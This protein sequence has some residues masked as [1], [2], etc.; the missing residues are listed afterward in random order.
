MAGDA[1]GARAAVERAHALFAAHNLD[2]VT[3]A[4]LGRAMIRNGRVAQA[5][6]VVDSARAR[7]RP[8]NQFEDA[9]SLGASADLALARG[10]ADSARA[11][12]QRAA[13]LDSS[14][15]ALA[16]LAIARVETG[17]F[18]GAVELE[19]RMR[20]THSSVGYE[21]QMPWTLSRYRLGRLDERM[22]NTAAARFR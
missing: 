22:G 21:A 2:A 6:R 5:R 7:V 11:L 10:A 9:Q 4:R 17:D 20:R 1:A 3:T 8:G 18:A 14:A 12:Y 13:V 16:P 19:K 15:E